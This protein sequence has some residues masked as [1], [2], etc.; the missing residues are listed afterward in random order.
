MVKIVFTII[1]IVIVFWYLAGISCE[2]RAPFLVLLI[3]QFLFWSYISRFIGWILG[4]MFP[5]IAA[6]F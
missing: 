3:G 5:G 6:L 4:G 1:E 2:T